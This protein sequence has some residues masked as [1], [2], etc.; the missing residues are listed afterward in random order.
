MTIEEIA[1]EF[2]AHKSAL[3]FCHVRPDGDTL[4]AAFALK[5]AMEKSGRIADI[6]CE[7]PI[8]DKY[9]LVGAASSVLKPSEISKKYE[10][11]I[12]VDCS[13]E[14][15]MGDAYRF[16]IR[17]G[18]TY[19]IDHHVS[20]S[21]YAKFNY[22]ENRAACCEIMYRFI[23]C[24]G[25]GIDAETANCLLLGISTDTGHFMHSNVD[26][27]TLSVAAEL[28]KAGGDVHGIG[29]K[30][31]KSQPKSRALLFATATSSMRFYLDDK[32]AIISIFK[33]DLALAGAT[34]DMTEGF[35]DFPLSV[36]G[37]EVAVSILEHN[38]NQ[39]KISYRSKGK[40]NVNE[41]AAVFGGG[42]HAMAS[43]SMI[44]GFY[45]DVK[46]KIIEAVSAF[47]Q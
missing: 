15:M 1:R 45:E 14:N 26:A 22:V 18:N 7:S 38:E 34:S 36:D 41:V 47:L 44:N 28:V 13:V 6:V 16:F 32:L 19:N 5:I 27:N 24:L 11:H 40:V 2:S 42:G 10:A 3:V 8:P 23:K 17:N 20:N 4:G 25:I 35:I 43:G 37:V 9:K 33:K 21:G 12:A 31:F 30:I 39:Y 46:N 29:Y